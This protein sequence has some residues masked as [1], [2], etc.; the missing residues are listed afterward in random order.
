MQETEA[1][2]KEMP[3]AL[4]LPCL[5]CGEPLTLPLRKR[6]KVFVYKAQCPECGMESKM[7]GVQGE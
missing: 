1:K 7:R 4:N 3:A 6:G 2:P 5:A